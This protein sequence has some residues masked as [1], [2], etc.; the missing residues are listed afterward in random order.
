[1]SC[2]AE[3]ALTEVV[4]RV[5]PGRASA[6]EELRARIVRF[7]ADPS[8]RTLLLRGPVGAGKSTIARLVSFGKRIAPL[9]ERAARELVGDLRFEQPGRI[10]MRSMPWYVEFTATGL[11][12]E[13]ACA[14]LYGIKR[15]AA[16]GVE[17]APGVFERAQAGPNGEP[18]DGATI[19]G[20][21][22]FLDEIGDLSSFLQAKLLPVL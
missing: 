8:A 22:V 14:Q 19:T 16:T 1:M 5:L 17:G 12:D 2:P 9:R 7:C 11:V 21:V 3:A 18:W 10:D 13:L 15:G 20:G 4:Q 6:T